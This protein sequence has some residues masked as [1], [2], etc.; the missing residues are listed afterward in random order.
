MPWVA[1]MAFLV[2]AGCGQGAIGGTASSDESLTACSSAAVGLSST[3]SE[4]DRDLRQWRQREAIPGLA[5]GVVCGDSLVWARGYGVRANDD[6]S[7][8][9]PRTLFRVASLTKVFTATAVLKLAAEGKLDLD[10]PIRE[11]LPWFSIRRPAETGVAPITIRQLL[12]HTA[13]VPRDS[14]LTDFGRIY[15]PPR[16]DAIAALPEQRLEA[17]PGERY[18]YSNLGYGLLGEIISSASGLD[19]ANYVRREILTPLGMAEAIV[20]PRHSDTTAWGHGPRRPDGTRPKAGFWELG[21]A[22]PA[23]GMASNIEELSRFVL[24]HLAPYGP[25]QASF[26][27][28]DLLLEMHRVQ[29]VIDPLRGGP[30]LGWAVETSA[31]QHLIYHAGELPEQSSFLL[32]DLQARIGVIVLANAQDAGVNPK[33]QEILRAV[34]VAVLDTSRDVP[35]PA[36]P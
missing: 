11:H 13:G 8:V 12:T 29:H 31:G 15:Q 25:G 7:H 5:A 18:A 27:A 21:F 6:P 19:Y 14:R 24:L 1:L 30:G 16:E 23:G 36:I 3:F 9:T 33:A 26:L 28:A 22:T 4:I 20:H 34:R 10:D 17:R 35:H 2:T 32:L